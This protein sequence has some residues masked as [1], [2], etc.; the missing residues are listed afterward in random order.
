MVNWVVWSQCCVACVEVDSGVGVQQEILGKQ[1]GHVKTFQR[2]D[3]AGDGVGV[4]TEMFCE[5]A[6][7][8]VFEVDRWV[9]CEVSPL[10][11]VS[12][13]HVGSPHDTPHYT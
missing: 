3:G 12:H 6:D 10:E 4:C 13:K 2:E 11:H 5:T 8:M 9:L 1:I 7:K